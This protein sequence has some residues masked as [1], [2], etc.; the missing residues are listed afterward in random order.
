MKRV[1]ILGGGFGGLA[2]ANELKGALGSEVDITVVDKRDTTD[3]RPSYL[4]VMIGYREPN[5][6]SAPLNLLSKR[7]IEFV[8][9]E[10][11]KIDPA[12]RT[13][14]T[15]AGK[16]NYDYLIIS[17]GAE[18]HPELVRGGPIIHP[19]E[20][21]WALKTREAVKSFRKGRL[22]VA[23]HSTPYRCPPAP[24]ETALLLDYFYS[25]LGRRGDITITMVHPFK[26]P[27]ENFGPLAAKLM[28]GMMA[29]RKIEWMGLG[30][31]PAVDYVDPEKKELVTTTGERVKYDLLIL[32]PPH[33]PPKAVAESDIA[34]PQTGWAVATPPTFRTKYDDVYAIGDV[35][36]PSV[37]LG[38][39]GVIAH[40]YLK[41][42]VA[43]IVSDIK[44]TYIG[45]DF[46]IFASCALDV[47]GFG[48]AAACD[49]TK[50]A[51]K[52]APLPDCTFL[53]PSS[54]VRVFKEFF[55]K[56]YFAWLLKYVPG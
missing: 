29:E 31:N 43:S 20:L 44:G 22:V 27:F 41:Y 42:V 21:D 4:Y 46:R 28:E 45:S 11:T 5:Q 49:F 48:M 34:N 7:G 1:L 52:Q 16:L 24:W 23:V 56:E 19:W 8:K 40:S 30:R 15:T 50:L 13:V 32:I 25:G 12:N 53:P 3:F 37:G 54:T 36:A 6:I 38:M 14:E 9:A 18:T 26:R 33:R 39:A 35:V 51:L 55:E 2:A 17:L 10:V 47:G